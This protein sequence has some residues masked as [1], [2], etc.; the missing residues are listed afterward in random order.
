M[1]MKL[2]NHQWYPA[3]TSTLYSCRANADAYGSLPIHQ[4]Y[5]SWIPRLL[6]VACENRQ[7]KMVFE[8]KSRVVEASIPAP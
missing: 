2:Q 5:E 1:L 7:K 4:L 3:K 8:A 6:A